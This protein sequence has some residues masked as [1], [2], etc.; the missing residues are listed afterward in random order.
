MQQFALGLH[1]TASL[2]SRYGSVNEE[3]EAEYNSNA[4]L[5]IDNE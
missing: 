1:E 2:N 3:F 5:V 4:S